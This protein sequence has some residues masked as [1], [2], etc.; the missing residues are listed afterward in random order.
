[1]RWGQSHTSCWQVTMRRWQLWLQWLLNVLCSSL[2]E[3]LP[4][5]SLGDSGFLILPTCKTHFA[6]FVIQPDECSSSLHLLELLL[7]FYVY[8][9]DVSTPM[10]NHTM[11]DFFKVL[12]AFSY[13]S[14]SF[15]L[16]IRNGL[17]DF[18]FDSQNLGFFV[19]LWFC[20]YDL[21]DIFWRYYCY[22]DVIKLDWNRMWNLHDLQMTL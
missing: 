1:M 7:L 21:N 2:S 8:L 10:Y 17:L 6:V 15:F 18:G 14:V 20:S 16:G 13:I 9:V 5:F 4:W 3:E 11:Q 12:D 22:I 19:F